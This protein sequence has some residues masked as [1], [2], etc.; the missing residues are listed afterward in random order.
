MSDIAAISLRDLKF[1]YAGAG[2]GGELDIERFDVAQGESV[3]LQG[4]SGSGKS[5]LLNLIGGVLKPT[6]GEI[7]LLGANLSSLSSSGRD[8][9]R[10]DHLGYVFQMFNLLPYLDVVA[11]V[12]LALTFSP[13]RRSRLDG[14]SPKS[15]AQR[16]LNALGLDESVQAK[17]VAQLSVG[18]Q[19]RVA[20]ARALIGG[21]ELIVADEP[22]SALDAQASARFVRLLLTQAANAGASVVF[23]S[24]EASLAEHFD[25]AIDIATLNRA[26]A[27][28]YE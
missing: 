20:C 16:L 2:S 19:Q 11:N 7:S 13:R 27:A 3:F 17:R 25:R 4:A 1:S 24:H 12:T 5:T 9:F 26:E 22:T 15:E 8:A 18:Q 21:P 23:V 14:V 10:A 28:S 6:S